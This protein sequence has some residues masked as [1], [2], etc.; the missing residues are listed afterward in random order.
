MYLKSFSFMFL[1]IMLLP[2]VS[3]RQQIKRHET[4]VLMSVLIEVSP[5]T[6]EETGS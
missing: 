3:N 2:Q 6:L 1:S 4:Y 5:N